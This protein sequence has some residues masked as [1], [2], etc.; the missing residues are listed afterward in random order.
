MTGFTWCILLAEADAADPAQ[1]RGLFGMLPAMIIIMI[2]YFVLFL[3]PQRQRDSAHRTQ[4]EGLKKNDRVV[5]I[6]GIYGTVTNVQR[7]S[8]E[9]TLKV[10][11]ATNA[12]LRVTL[13]SIARVITEDNAEGSSA[14]K[15]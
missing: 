13:N 9:V 14:P 5:T 6:G 15:T 2:L 7:E 11:E 3:R 4:L 10:D 12:K 8:D 1:G